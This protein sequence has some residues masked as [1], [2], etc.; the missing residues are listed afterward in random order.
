MITSKRF[1]HFSF[2]APHAFTLVEILVVI[3]LVGLVS[4]PFTRMFL[5]GTKGSHDNS[6]HIAAYN[7]A[8]EKIEEVRSLPFRMVRSD[9]DNFRNIYR[10]R[11]GFDQLFEDK[12]L[13]DAA[14]S[15][16]FTE[17][18]LA[19]EETKTTYNRFSDLYKAA[20]RRQYELYPRS[21]KGFRRIIDVDDQ[22]DTTMPPR[23]KK[24]NVKVF[25]KFGK[26]V[27][28]LVTLIGITK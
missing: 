26:K 25:N 11:P 1:N 23:L 24:I 9:F 12:A 27:A 16:I 2:P 5:L 10:D 22:Y 3:F 13:F 28:E 4:L 21:L 15:D 19:D 8:R 14:F 18:C 7:L 6:E 17:E 20:F